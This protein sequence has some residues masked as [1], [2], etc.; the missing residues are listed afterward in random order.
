MATYAK[1]RVSNIRPERN[2][3][4]GKSVRY[5]EIRKSDLP[6]IARALGLSVPDLVE[7]AKRLEEDR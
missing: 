5:S 1:R 7:T 3:S 4:G 6:V 2:G